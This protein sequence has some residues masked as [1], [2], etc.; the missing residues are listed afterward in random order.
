LALPLLDNLLAVIKM[1]LDDVGYPNEK[2]YIHLMEQIK[3]RR[4]HR[5][6]NVRLPL[7]YRREGS[8]RGGM[9]RTVTVN[10]STGG[11]YFE[12][13]S[14]ELHPGDKLQMEMGVPEGEERF[15]QHSKIRTGGQV[16]R[17]H[18]IENEPYSEGVEYPRYG[19]G[20][21]FQQG[22]RLTF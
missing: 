12:T 6:L 18:S 3:E 5:R 14:D 8:I 7:E 1:L 13:V 17:I 10:V 11:V 4:K 16:V 20:V 21:L 15:P 19:V 2:D 22:F 9:N